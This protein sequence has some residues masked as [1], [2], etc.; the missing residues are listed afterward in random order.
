MLGFSLASLPQMIKK[1]LTIRLAT[2]I[3]H[4]ALTENTF[5]CLFL[6][7]GINW[8]HYKRCSAGWR[9]TS[10]GRK[11]A[12]EWTRRAWNCVT[13]DRMAPVAGKER[14]SLIAAN[15]WRSPPMHHNLA[16][17]TCQ[18]A[19]NTGKKGFHTIQPF[20][21]IRRSARLLVDKLI[22]TNLLQ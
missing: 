3:S 16:P 10:Q 11:S 14:T 17:R 6:L 21:K 1:M 7:A 19:P 22:R 4:A 2:E 18:F 9:K 5:L 12:W 8:T 15:W 20:R 13:F